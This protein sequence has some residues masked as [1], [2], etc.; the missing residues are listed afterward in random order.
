MHKTIFACMHAK[1][2]QS[3]PTLCDP[4]DCSLPGFSFHGIFQA[5]ILEL[6]AMPSS[7]LSFVIQ[8]LGR[9]ILFVTPWTAAHQASLF[10]TNS[11]SLLTF[12]S[13]E[14]EMP[15]NHFL[16]H[17]L[18]LLPSVFSSIRFFFNGL[19]LCIRWPNYWSFSFSFNPSN[20][21][22]GLISFRISWFYL[23]AVQETLK[24]LLQ[25]HSSKASILLH[26][27]FFIVQLSH[28]YMT[29]EKTITLIVQPLSAK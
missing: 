28:P 27:V 19:A 26:S 8:F 18:L 2:L 1:S 5:R 29:T 7:N 16:L 24:S 14:L 20:E 6:V 17:P 11:Q 13:I 23:V 15:F 21:Y 25:H 3:C 9:V 4:M 22:S 10:F 12:M